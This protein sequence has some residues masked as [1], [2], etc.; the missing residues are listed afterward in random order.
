V[1]RHEVMLSFIRDGP[2]FRRAMA[3]PSRDCSFRP[4]P[5]TSTI[6]SAHHAQSASFGPTHR[7]LYLFC[8]ISCGEW[9]WGTFWVCRP[10]CH[11]WTTKCM[12]V[13][14][15]GSGLRRRRVFGTWQAHGTE[16]TC[17]N[18]CSFLLL[19]FGLR[20]RK[21]IF[22][23]SHAPKANKV[24]LTTAFIRGVWNGSPSECVLRKINNVELSLVN[25]H[26]SLMIRWVKM[27]I[28]WSCH[29]SAPKV[30]RGAEF[31]HEV[32]AKLLV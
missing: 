2:Q 20:K 3:H 8:A 23:H 4:W 27:Q 9:S 26:S 22:K 15:C 18:L 14:L 10:A 21:K 17:P 32:G 1:V 19:P 13:Q 24:L 28:L 5:I 12:G 11:G 30:K 31:F 25:L 29:G 7:L 16:R 6:A